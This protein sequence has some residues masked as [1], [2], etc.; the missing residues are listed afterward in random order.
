MTL[1]I[2]NCNATMALD[3]QA[4]ARSLKSAT[5]ITVHT[6][7]CRKEIESFTSA[8]KGDECVVACTQEAQ[9]FTELATQAKS[10]SALKFVNIRE[11]AGWSAEGAR[12]TPKIAALLALADMP[13]PEPVPAVSYRSGGE[14]LVIGPAEAALDWAERLSAQLSVSVLVVG[15]PC[16]ELPAERRYA[17]WSGKPKSVSGYLGAFEVVWEQSNPIDL[18]VCTRC[19]ACIHACP[20]KAIDFS[21]QID[22]ERCRSHRQCVKACGAI[23]AIDFDRVERERSD[24]FDLVLDLTTEP[25]IR[26]AQAPQGYLAPGSDPLQQA[27]AANTLAQLVGEFEKPKFVVYNERICVHGRSNKVGCTNCIDTCSTGAITP[28]G[29]GVKVETHVCAGCGGCSSVCPTGAL[30]HSFPRVTELGARIKRLLAVYCGAGGKDA[31][32]LFHDGALSRELLM[33]SA[34]RAQSGKAGGLPARVIPLEVHHPASI[35]MDVWLGAIAYGASQIVLLATRSEAAEYGAALKG[36]MGHAQAVLSALGYQ[37]EHLRLIEAEDVAA[38]EREIRSLLPAATVATPATFNLG[39]EKRLTL[40]FAIEH[41]AKLAPTPNDEIAL[42]GGAPWGRVEVNTEKCTLCLACVGA[43]PARALLDT[44]ETPRL[45]F[46][47]R[48]CVQC[49]LCQNTCPEDAITLKPRLLLTAR[50]REAV[51]LA[52]TEP[53]LCVRCGKPFGARKLI[54]HLAAKLAGHSMFEGQP[55]LARLQM[56]ADCRV[57]DMM[58]NPKEVSVF[59]VK[60]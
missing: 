14:L 17:L 26:V 1:K 29:N 57:I 28:D 3:A 41:L 7:L 55:E 6:E 50:S 56:C 16:G 36:Q 54:D 53:G 5:P 43:C 23:G 15:P 40:E 59:D 37:G 25:L 39:A 27:L 18:E 30:T 21:Y 38:L 22:L 49:G 24:R 10:S 60:P 20:E 52:E 58:E 8:L 4:L 12:A 47:E 35:G 19:N 13:E 32:L 45:R 11:M 34:R 9:L 31:C 33:R 46:I 48:N 42:S 51:T 2:C 44:A